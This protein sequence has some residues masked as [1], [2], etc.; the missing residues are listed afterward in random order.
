MSI[1]KAERQRKKPP[2]TFLQSYC[3][4]KKSLQGSIPWLKP[5]SFYMVSFKIMFF[6]D[7]GMEP[8]TTKCDSKADDFFWR[9]IIIMRNSTEINCF[10]KLRQHFSYMF[11]SVHHLINVLSLNTHKDREGIMQRMWWY[12]SSLYCT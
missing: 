5:S 11:N 9:K 7:W 6:S 10:P 4:H 12:A 8:K 2:P 3:N 1:I